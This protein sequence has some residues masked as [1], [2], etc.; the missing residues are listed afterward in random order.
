MPILALDL[1][2]TKLSSSLFDE[3]G[4]IVSRKVAL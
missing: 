3:Q 2:G 1:G 4:K